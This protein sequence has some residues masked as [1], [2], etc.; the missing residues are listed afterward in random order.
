MATARGV[1][2]GEAFIKL[3]T[4]N[5][6][7]LRGLDAARKNLRAFGT[8]VTAI[9]A[10]VAGLGT[11]GLGGLFAAAKSFS[12]AG[13]KI[14]KAAIRTGLS[15]EAVS[16]LGFAA[17]QSG[18][19]LEGFEK[20]FRKFQQMLGD[21]AKGEPMAVE[22]LNEIGLSVEA[23]MAMHP[24]DQV[25]AL[26][27]AIA[28]IDDPARRT[29]AAMGILGKAGADLIPLFE[30]GADAVRALRKE[31]EE[32][33]L[34]FTEADA[35]SAAAL[36]D[37]LNALTRQLKALWQWI[38]SAVAPALSDMLRAASPVVS[39]VIEWV[40]ANRD[41]VASI[42]LWSGVAA[43][44]GGALMAI[45]LGI[46]FVSAVLGSIITLVT[47]ATAVVAG[48]VAVVANIPVLLIAAGIGAVAAFT[49][50]RSAAGEALDWISEKLD[51]LLA[52][53]RQTWRGIADALATGDI[54]AAAEIMWVGLE[55]VW[56]RGVAAI[57]EIWGNLKTAV[58]SAGYEV[59]AGWA[60]IAE[61]LGHLLE[62]A[63][64]SAIFAMMN[65]W[66]KFQAFFMS[67]W[68]KTTG[69][70]ADRLLEAYGAADKDFDVEAAKKIRRE[71]DQATLGDIQAERDQTLAGRKQQQQDLEAIRDARLKAKQAE[72][73]QA[74]IDAQERLAA[75]N[76]ED[77]A[78]AQ[79]E[80]D[81][82]QARLD[83]L[84][85]EAAL[86]RQMAEEGKKQLQTAKGIA[87]AGGAASRNQASVGSF[88]ALAITSF[89]PDDLKNPVE[90]TAE[91]AENIE[92]GVGR[93]AAAIGD[94]GRTWSFA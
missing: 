38:G 5:S 59:L 73:A 81:I 52:T 79:A 76:A 22:A 33:G 15:A 17:E 91:A 46:V 39:A 75:A 4:D 70:V 62:G 51:A 18:S 37:A 29:E 80:I 10:G 14:D 84:T 13:D 66:T 50:M 45:G 63:L 32:L 93:I 72:I 67:T 88:S 86:R 2:A 24:D 42:A 90:R 20:G 36:N 47:T 40:K 53:G 83:M 26:A 64:F 89:R 8:A 41:L 16:E 19:S 71:N 77:R 9:G 94:I 61:R 43:A 68:H 27:D 23:L 78:A 56:K 65:A 92:R 57:K 3:G 87:A 12:D 25:Y 60:M 1:K 11:A 28:A 74:L 69:W 58:L 54:Q 35:K 30:G 55:L 21:A 49:D 34:T 31:A 6:A 44:A 48:L 7:L 85:E 82:L